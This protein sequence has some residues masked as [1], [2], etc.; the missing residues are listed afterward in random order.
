MIHGR[1][2][3]NVIDEHV[4][5]AQNVIE[6]INRRQAEASR[7]LTEI[8]NQTAEEFRRLARFRL[9]E[10]TANR[11]IARLDETDRAVL[12]L[13]ERRARELNELEAG[14]Q[15]I[16][17]RQ[18]ALTF[19][20]EAVVRR[21]DELVT[22][23]DRQAADI[24]AQLATQEPY[25]A[26]EKSAGEASAK[27]ER[28]EAKAAQ[29]EA[30]REEKGRPYREDALFMYLWNRRFLTPDY[31]GGGLTRALDGWVAK[32]IDFADARSNYFML[33]ELPLRLR[34]HA[35]RQ[36]VIAAQESVKLRSL[37]E[38]ALQVEGLRQ[39]NE[40][41]LAT[42]K[43]I[44][45]IEARIEAAEKQHQALIEKRAA[46]SGASDELAQQALQ[47][48]VSEIKNE[49]LANLLREAQTT[50]RPEDD[51]I[52]SRIRD[53]KEAE[54]T[55]SAEIERLQ[56]E[57]QRQQKSFQEIEELRRRFRRSGYDS[58][59]SYFPGGL[60]LAALLALLMSGRASGQD[61]WGRIGREQEFRPPRHRQGQGGGGDFFPGG[62]GR[63]GGGSFPDIFGGGGGSGG[64][65]GEI[66]G[67]GFRTGGGF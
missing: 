14:I 38:Q 25:R 61:V 66:G 64:G 51:V 30:D 13:L 50:S 43:E 44:E 39:K 46:Y 11:V 34:E 42:R 2:Q 31:T 58:G 49:P 62:F 67:G 47:L 22:E 63:G 33:T 1:D 8:R 15:E 9:D 41:L 20:R 59:H 52:V 54:Q 19:E 28:A 17:A 55:L 40:A 6:S 12:S 26:Q 56:S 21:R 53:L 36:K 27:A 29:A 48:Q 10:L 23:I 4:A 65:G 24:R 3:L 37:E 32:L 60:D 45:G 7:Q 35:E 5:T 57:L 18:S 16:V